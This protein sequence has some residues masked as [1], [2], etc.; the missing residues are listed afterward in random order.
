MIDAPVGVVVPC[1]NEAARLDC[2]AILALAS[3]AAVRVLL[4]DD[5]SV[6][7]TAEM[8][9][10]LASA[11]DS[12]EVVVLATNLGKAEAVRQGM[13]RALAGDAALVAYY[14]ADLATPPSELL[15]LVELIRARPEVACAMGARVALLGTNIERRWTRHYAGRLFA[16][17]ASIALGIGVYDTQCGAKVFRRSPTL[18]AA[19]A[20]PFRSRWAFDVELLDRLLRPQSAVAPIAADAL[21]EVPLREWRDVPGSRMRVSGGV[22]AFVDLARL[23]AARILSRR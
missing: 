19:L 12:I 10:E 5:G 11:S 3:E 1:Y 20:R 4:V 17:A 2:A 8:L 16:S 9:R 21:V 7:G 14:D 15:R 22:S 23:G 13:V 18:S 6:D